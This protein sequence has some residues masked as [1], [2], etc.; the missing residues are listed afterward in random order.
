M[1]M[2]ETN[3]LGVFMPSH[4]DLLPVLQNISEKYKFPEISPD[5]DLIKEIY[6]GM[7]LYH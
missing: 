1:F 2:R 4:P 6:L 3:F 5:D 7:K